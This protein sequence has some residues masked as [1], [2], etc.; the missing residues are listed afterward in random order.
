MKNFPIKKCQNRK[1]MTQNLFLKHCLLKSLTFFLKYF[2]SG[3]V[4][5]HVAQKNLFI[6]NR[7]EI[8]NIN[9]FKVS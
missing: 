2:S 5:R 9:R 8:R 1:Q 4:L 6:T 3:L 7:K